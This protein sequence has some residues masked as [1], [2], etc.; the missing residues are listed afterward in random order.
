MT[1]KTLTPAPVG[2]LLLDVTTDGGEVRVRVDPTATAA[3][4]TIRT[5]D[6][7]GPAA[8]AA[9]GASAVLSGQRLTV[10]VP[11]I[12][13]ADGSVTIGNM[14]F[15]GG[16]QFVQNVTTVGRGQTLTGVSIVNGKVIGGGISGGLAVR[17]VEVLV[18]LPAGSGVKMQTK[19]ANLTVTGPLAALDFNGYN[20][21]VR[22]GLVGRLKVDTYNGDV[23][24]D[25]VQDWADAET[26]NG[27]IELGSYSGGSARLITYNGDVSLS[28]TPAASGVLLTQTYNGDIRL[29]GTDN[30]PEL[31]V[32]R[33][34]G[35]R[36]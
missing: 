32:T 29:R 22:A 10:R 5:D 19:N 21:D 9:R 17:P 31:N 12:E 23:R 24:A 33:R 35:N 14:T 8:E 11:K 16:V 1:E 26:Y 15:N 13:G 25:G 18:T 7:D 4:V 30:R 28:A 36:W 3:S 27:D 20:G 6:E 2:P 34:I